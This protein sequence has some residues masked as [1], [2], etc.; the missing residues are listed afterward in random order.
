M[1]TSEGRLE[2]KPNDEK[3]H[4]FPFLIQK[5]ET[6]SIN[7][8]SYCSHKS[9]YYIVIVSQISNFSHLYIVF[10]AYFGPHGD[11]S[12]VR[13]AGATS[14]TCMGTQYIIHHKRELAIVPNLNFALL[15]NK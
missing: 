7:Y 1:S 8:Q 15:Y 12:S 10:C 9:K 5:A 13:T 2:E 4:V 3:R 6:A 14:L 11:H